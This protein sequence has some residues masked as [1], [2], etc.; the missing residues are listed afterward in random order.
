RELLGLDN[1]EDIIGQI[2]EAA[3][4]D[5]EGMEQ[6]AEAVKSGTVEDI[7][8]AD[9]VIEEMDEEMETGLE[10]EPEPESE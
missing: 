8:S 6:E 5:I 7:K 3:E 1:I 2:D 9:E 4:V 10:G